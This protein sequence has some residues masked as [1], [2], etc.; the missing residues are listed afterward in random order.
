M[1]FLFIITVILLIGI[2][3]TGTNEETS[4]VMPPESRFRVQV[5]FPKS[6]G[7]REEF[8]ITILVARNDRNDR[9]E[10]SGA[11][12]AELRVGLPPS[13][14]LSADGYKVLDSND[15]WGEYGY[16]DYLQQ[17]PIPP[18]GV[19][20]LLRPAVVELAAPWPLF[21]MISEPGKVGIVGATL[22]SKRVGD[23][24]EWGFEPTYEFLPAYDGTHAHDCQG[25]GQ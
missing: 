2:G 22:F 20:L 7:V 16:C 25:I 19:Q 21:I 12:T 18:K 4:S 15:N 24:L 13:L 5:T 14:S 8:P 9:K 3:C 6:T 11:A 17:I 1:R 23:R 10:G